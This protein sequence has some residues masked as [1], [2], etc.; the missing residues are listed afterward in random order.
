MFES[1]SY[2]SGIE[3]AIRS[4]STNV[5]LTIHVTY[6]Y[7]TLDSMDSLIPKHDAFIYK[8]RTDL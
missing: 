8:H 6:G 2:E 5:A 1:T 4:T 3:I 7:E